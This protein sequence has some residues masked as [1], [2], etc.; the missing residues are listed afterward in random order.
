MTNFTETKAPNWGNAQKKMSS[1]WLIVK[2]Q[3]IIVLSFQT[4]VNWKFSVR[5]CW[6]LRVKPQFGK[7]H[8]LATNKIYQAS[9]NKDRFFISKT[10]LAVISHWLW[11]G[12]DEVPRRAWQTLGD[13]WLISIQYFITPYSGDNR[14]FWNRVSR[15]SIIPMVAFTIWNIV[16]YASTSISLDSEKYFCWPEKDLSEW[17]RRQGWRVTGVGGKLTHGSHHPHSQSVQIAPATKPLL[18]FHLFSHGN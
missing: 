7:R 17:R 3:V 12:S 5:N 13:V 1:L 2:F 9:E 14:D 18:R 15:C 4:A 6:Y 11:R 8:H 16:S 10:W